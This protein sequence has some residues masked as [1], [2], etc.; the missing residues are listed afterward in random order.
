MT[1]TVPTAKHTFTERAA[2]GNLND[3]QILNSNNAAGSDLPNQSDVVIAGGGI[4]GLIY[5]IHSAK[6]KPGNLSIS[7]IEKNSKPGYKI[8]ESTLPVFAMWC[9]MHGLTAEYLLRIFGVKD[10]L[11]FYFLDRENPGKYSDFLING[12]PGHYLS[13]YQL[14]RP[15]S[16]LLLTLLAQ[17][18]G[19]NV[20]HGKKINFGA[21]T[22]EGG[23]QNSKIK[24]AEAK[25]DGKPVATI[26]TSLLVDATGRFRQLASKNASLHRFEG[27]NT[28]AFWGYFTCLKDESKI[29]FR[30]HEG[31][32]TNH[33]CFPEG[34]FWVIRLL[35]WQGNPTANLMDMLTYLLDCAEAGLPGDQIPSTEELANMFGLKF[36]WVTSIGVAARNDVQYPEDM[37]EYGS[38]EAERKFNY[39]VRKYPLIK[40]SMAN[41]ELIE[42][43]YG[44][45]TTWF[46]RKTLTYQSPVV[47]GPG[48]FAI[49]DACGFTNPLYSPGI[50][51]G[52]ASSTYAAELTHKAL[53]DARQSANNVEDAELSI[54]KSLAPY[55]DFVKRL[56]PALDQMNRFNYVCFRDPRLGPQVSCVWQYFAGAMAGY[57][58]VHI[59]GTFTLTP[60]AFLLYAK[61]WRWGSMVPEYNTVARKAIELIGPIPLEDPVPDVTV[62]ELIEFSNSMKTAALESNRAK[63]VR[64]AGKLRTHDNSLNYREEKTSRDRFTRQCSH[65]ASWLVLRSDWKKCYSCGKK[66][67]D[68]EA[69]IIWNP[70]LAT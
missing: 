56:I 64:W 43:L 58:P 19:V 27:F 40:E 11:A 20:Y 24:I 4:H 13:G 67:A 63:D 32:H 33:W 15:I 1:V 9:K 54:R 28:D 41:F 36:Q 49:G 60:P 31:S 45:G 30:Y 42:N 53:D 16:E 21:S 38:T 68:E 23:V 37:S 52:M 47:S 6:L 25:V 39:F 12:T 51:V 29:P 70:P 34:W 26:D 35:S 7:L 5:A 55:D 2:V 10:G 48:W 46:V 66:R 8:G 22:V 61:N 59:E 65:C 14:E 17:R 62:R 18:N 50:N 57:D 69:A 3:A 44:P